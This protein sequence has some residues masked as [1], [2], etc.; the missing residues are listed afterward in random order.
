M[1]HASSLQ[2]FSLEERLDTAAPLDVP[3]HLTERLT[4]E[5]TFKIAFDLAGDFASGVTDPELLK[6]AFKQAPHGWH[7]KNFQLVLH[8]KMLGNTPGPS[9]VVAAYFW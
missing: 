7:G 8:V 1:L 6:G 9:T 2:V 5:G 4:E 3:P